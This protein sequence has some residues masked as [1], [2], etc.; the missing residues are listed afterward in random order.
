[1]LSKN[2][3]KLYDKLYAYYYGPVLYEKHNITPIEKTPWYA[4]FCN[5]ET[6]EC[7]F[8]NGM[9]S[10]IRTKDERLGVITE[11]FES[12]FIRFIWRSNHKNHLSVAILLSTPREIASYRDKK[13]KQT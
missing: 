10:F 9:S 13:W 4:F 6:G 3:N 12:G 5:G 1:M 7:F 11:L 8:T 2:A